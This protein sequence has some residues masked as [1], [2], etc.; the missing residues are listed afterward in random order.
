MAST[1]NNMEFKNDISSEDGSFTL[2]DAKREQE[3]LDSVDLEEIQQENSETAVLTE[4]MDKLDIEQIPLGTDKVLINRRNLKK[5]GE[6][7]VFKD[8]EKEEEEMKGNFSDQ[9]IEE[10]D[11]EDLDGDEEKDPNFDEKLAIEEM[12]EE[13]EL[14]EECED[15]SR[16]SVDK[17][18]FVGG[19][20]EKESSGNCKLVFGDVEK[21][22]NE[23]K[24]EEENEDEEEQ[25]Q[26]TECM[27]T[28]EWNK[29]IKN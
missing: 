5:E 25:G 24:K 7:F 19:V 20:A 14:D 13:V 21:F 22:R 27:V 23:S 29:I 6:M 8:E 4:T 18:E 12:K 9:N 26:G 1:I 3:S 28:R 16:E 10:L 15:S 11:S 17:D 2:E